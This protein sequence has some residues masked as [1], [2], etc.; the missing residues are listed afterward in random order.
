MNEHRPAA[1]GYEATFQKSL[2][3]DS[4]IIP[5]IRRRRDAALRCQP[6]AEDG[7]RDPLDPPAPHSCECCGRTET[8]S[9]PVD[10]GLTRAELLAHGEA[11]IASGWAS[12]EIRARLVDPRAVDA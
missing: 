11:L 7:R 3:G 2:D 6:L 5:Q 1:G 10:Y 4:S 8:H 12:W 9:Q